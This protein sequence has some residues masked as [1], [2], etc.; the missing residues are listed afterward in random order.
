MTV[1][2]SFNIWKHITDE[3]KQDDLNDLFNH[4]DRL[5]IVGLQEINWHLTVPNGWDVYQPTDWQA[6]KDPILWKTSVWR[7]IVKDST[8]L[9]NRVVGDKYTYPARYGNW[10][11]YESV[12]SPDRRLI[13][14][15]MHLNAN[16]TSPENRGLPNGEVQQL[17]HMRS[18]YELMRLAN[19]LY[20]LYPCP[21]LLT[22]DLNVDYGNDKRE[23]HPEFPYSI[24]TGHGFHS[25][26]ELGEQ[27]TRSANPTGG[28]TI[29]YG[30]G[31]HVRWVSVT[32]PDRWTWLDP[33]ESDHLPVFMDFRPQYLRAWSG[34]SND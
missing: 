30:Y 17:E 8:L 1:A 29:D 27:S 15:N 21:I 24:F 23:Q 34:T 10:A 18:L 2:A 16:V 3:Q 26:W 33:I 19:N 4:D 14:I 25:V 11:V 22:G 9:S 32:T 7:A 31:R 13:H 20:S 12:K 5:S 28:G 6:S